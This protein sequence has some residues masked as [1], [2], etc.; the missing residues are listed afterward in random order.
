MTAKP[1]AQIK[2]EIDAFLEAHGAPI[3]PSPILREKLFD[4]LDSLKAYNAPDPHMIRLTY[5]GVLPPNAM[6]LG[7]VFV[8]GVAFPANLAGSQF[9][10]VVAPNEAYTLRILKNGEDAGAIAFAASE[11]IATLSTSDGESLQFE[12]GDLLQLVT[13][14]DLDVV[15]GVFGALAGTRV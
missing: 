1:V 9:R 6:V 12:P 15:S 5:P 2:A 14:A 11:T 4:I 8:V 7:E 3:D 13:Q 10:C